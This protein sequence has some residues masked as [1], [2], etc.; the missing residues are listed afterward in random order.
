M[1]KQSMFQVLDI[2]AHCRRGSRSGG[3]GGGAR[4]PVFASNYLKSPLSW[5][6]KL[7]SEQ[8]AFPL[9]SSPGSAPTLHLE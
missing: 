5:P 6:K 8:P 3:G 7:A 9:F 1:L 4:P 2:L